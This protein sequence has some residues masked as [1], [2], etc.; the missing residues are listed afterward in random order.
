M[1]G[2]RGMS[3]FGGSGGVDV[4]RDE[5]NKGPGRQGRGQEEPFQP[6]SLPV[7][8]RRLGFALGCFFGTAT[9]GA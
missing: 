8:L 6:L 1:F 9:F 2:M 5:G 7:V 4:G 3:G